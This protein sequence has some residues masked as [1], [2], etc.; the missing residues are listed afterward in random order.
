M[1]C[2][3]GVTSLMGRETAERPA[4]SVRHEKD[5]NILVNSIN[6]SLEHYDMDTFFY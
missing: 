6:S 4:A 5:V 2:S 1:G 3:S